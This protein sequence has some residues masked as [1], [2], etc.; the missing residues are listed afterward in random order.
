MTEEYLKELNALA[1]AQRSA[2]K[3]NEVIA[4]KV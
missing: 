4:S 2:A 1:F 3:L